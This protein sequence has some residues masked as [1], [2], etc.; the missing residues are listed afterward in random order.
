M[1][2][3]LTIDLSK[4]L[5]LTNEQLPLISI[6][7][8]VKDGCDGAV[9]RDGTGFNRDDLRKGVHNFVDYL[10]EETPERLQLS[11]LL[12]ALHMAV[13]YQRQWLNHFPQGTLD[14]V[15]ETQRKVKVQ[16]PQG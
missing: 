1:S 7:S 13:F 3:V 9:E 10:N 15:K 6:L 16:F 4:A 2:Q 5:N 11:N 12:W 14:R 8:A